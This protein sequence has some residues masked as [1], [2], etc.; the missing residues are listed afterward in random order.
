MSH[1]RSL[2]AR[3]PFAFASIAP[4]R[5][6]QRGGTGAQRAS[7]F[8]TWRIIRRV[9]DILRPASV[10]SGRAPAR[11]RNHCCC[12]CGRRRRGE[13]LFRGRGVISR[14]KFR[15]D[16]QSTRETIKEMKWSRA[17][18]SYVV[19]LGRQGWADDERSSPV[20]LRISADVRGT[21]EKWEQVMRCMKDMKIYP[22][23]I[24]V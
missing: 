7:P 14:D 12:T 13:A 3:D 15:W 16:R 21:A 2:Y 23:Y 18:G 6:K 11:A 10:R 24:A 4:T 1:R 20:E 22:E 8:N 5:T 19:Y 17:E 9:S